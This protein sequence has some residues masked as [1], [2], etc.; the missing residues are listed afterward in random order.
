MCS[1]PARPERSRIVRERPSARTPTG[2][3]ICAPGR[4]KAA[5][6]GTHQEPG[7]ARTPQ[8]AAPPHRPGPWVA[9]S[10]EK[11]SVR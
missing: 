10:G 9:G 5:A 3:P 6:R 4:V 8:E 1:A 11:G 2:N 7:P